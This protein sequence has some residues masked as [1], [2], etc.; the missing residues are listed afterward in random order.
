MTVNE[1][2]G[3]GL[4]RSRFRLLATGLAG[5]FVAAFCG[6][7]PAQEQSR[8]DA[9]IRLE[10]QYAHSNAFVSLGES[11][12]YWST[13]THVALLSGNYA[14]NDRWTVFA[15]LPYVRK[16]FNSEVP[17]GGDP[18]NP[19]DPY[20]VDFVPP[21]KRF[22]DDEKYHGAFQ[23]FSLGVSYRFAKGPFTFYPY[24][25][26]GVPA[27]DYPIFAKAAIGKNLWTI[28]VG[29]SI[30]YVPYFS[31]WHF[32]GDVAYV[33]SEKP[34]GRNVDYWTAHLSAGYWF[35]ANLSVKAF[36]T[37]RYGYGISLFSP[38]FINEDATFPPVY[39]LD[40]D[41]EEWWQ[42]DRLIG[43]RTLIGGLS[44]DY[45]LSPKWLLSGSTFRGVWTEEASENDFAFTVGITRFFEGQ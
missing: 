26:F 35:K 42:H 44:I 8:G 3:S 16:R 37:L 40:F 31:D 38:D 20:W 39:P 34:L 25:G 10:Y 30:S 36:V 6:A 13:D 4:R 32:D 43:N 19:N 12:D 1:A 41:T 17:W 22:W 33:F 5:L 11:F 2:P 45:A 28:P 15:A 24:I 21:D 27:T 18:H 29:T 23:D 9:S 14:L 7:V